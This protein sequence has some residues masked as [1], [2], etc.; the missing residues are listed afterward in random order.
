MP[1]DPALASRLH[2][3]S[4]MTSWD[5]QADPEAAARLEAWERDDEPYARPDV[6]T[7]DLTV[8]A[9]PE[10]FRL[11]MYGAGDGASPCLVWVHGGGFSGGDLEMNEADVVAREV[12]ARAGAVVASVDY[13]LGPRV[14]YPIPH[15]QVVA[16][17]RWV[18]DHAAD[19][20]IDPA[21]VTLGGASAGGALSIAAA[22]ELGAAGGPRP[23]SLVLAYPVAHSRCPVDPGQESAMTGLP[24]LLRFSPEVIAAMN[25]D[26]VAGHE[27][28]RWAFV[29]LEPAGDHAALEGL[30]PS[31]VLVSEYDDLRPTAELF[32]D[33]ARAAGCQVERRLCAGMLHGHLNRTPVLREVDASLDA[34]A[35]VVSD[36]G[37]HPDV[38]EGVVGRPCTD[39]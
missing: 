29:D 32:I 9:G 26:Y 31:L 14:T 30:P 2:L 17:V 5:Q 13:A 37:V 34:I 22:R 3:L 33:Q 8:M 39:G 16:A 20:G 6:P 35:R 38:G 19:L 28:P 23:T 21:R 4:G 25:G 36:G 12:V 18:V 24:G 10:P 15:R 27:N 7:R 1:L 11:R